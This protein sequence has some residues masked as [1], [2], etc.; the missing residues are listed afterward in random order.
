MKTQDRMDEEAIDL[1]KNH[2]QVAEIKSNT[3]NYMS[4]ASQ[5]TEEQMRQSGYGSYTRA[6]MLE[7]I[8]KDA[9]KKI[10]KI[11]KDH[12]KKYPD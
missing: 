12:I 7:S 1:A 3:F 11:W 8:L 6:E 9:Q 2:A 4:R 10:D 5:Y